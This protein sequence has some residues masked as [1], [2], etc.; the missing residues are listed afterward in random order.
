[1]HVV[2]GDPVIV[3]AT[4]QQVKSIWLHALELYKKHRALILYNDTLS[5]T[6]TRGSTKAH[7]DY[8]ASTRKDFGD[9]NVET[10]EHHVSRYGN[11]E[12]R[13]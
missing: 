8:S 1:M 3:S 13:R 6:G 10:P 12:G 9:R 2:A 5:Y 7:G 4:G 11:T